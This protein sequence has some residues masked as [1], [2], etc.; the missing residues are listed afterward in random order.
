MGTHLPLLMA[1][2][3]R[4]N[5]TLMIIGGHEEKDGD[6]LILKELARRVGNGKLVV[7]TIASKEPGSLWEAYEPVFR[8]LGVRNV[9]KLEVE[10]RED[11]KSP[12]ALRIMDDATAIFFTGGDQLKITSQIGLSPLCDR[13]QEMYEN[14]GLVAGTSAGA[15]V[16]TETMMVD[17][18]G[19]AS[20]RLGGRLALAPGLGLIR[21]IIVDQ[22]FSERGRVGRLLGAVAQNPRILGVGVDENTAVIIERDSSLQVLGAGGV[23]IIDGGAVSFSNVAEE[24]KERTLSIFDVRL[25]LLSQGDTY[26]CETRT[27]KFKPAEEFE[28]LNGLGES[29]D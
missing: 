15:S 19:E 6:K 26:D 4:T 3:K 5:R 1:E 14:G 18:D 9:Y 28:E 23:Y 7:A 21:G 11:A 17:G 13:I 29:D 16:M 12:R 24:Q 27:P 8:S 22:H 20:H 25:H 2:L 10:T